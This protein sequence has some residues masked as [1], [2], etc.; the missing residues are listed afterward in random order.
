MPVTNRRPSLIVS[1]RWA[2]SLTSWSRYPKSPPAEK[3]RPLPVTTA[4]RASGSAS[5]C[6]N[7]SAIAL[8][9]TWFVA[10]R[11]SGRLKRTMRTG[12]SISTWISSGRS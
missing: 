1:R 9:S 6:G 4:A 8:W 12:P 2:V 10:F 7:K 3:A 5:S 11:S